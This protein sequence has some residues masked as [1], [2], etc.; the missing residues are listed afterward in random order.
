MTDKDERLS[1]YQH[2]DD[3]ANLGNERGGAIIRGSLQGFY[4]YRQ[5]ISRLGYDWLDFADRSKNTREKIAGI[6]ALFFMAQY[7]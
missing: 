2:D 3:N 6:S 1:D 5:V 7:T 4:A